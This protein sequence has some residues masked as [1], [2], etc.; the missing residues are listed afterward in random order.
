MSDNSFLPQNPIKGETLK[1]LV[2]TELSSVMQASRGF[3]SWCSVRE[4]TLS[5]QHTA[6]PLGNPPGVSKFWSAISEIKTTSLQ[7]KGF[8]KQY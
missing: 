6:D 4:H 2:I 8:N 7:Y 3:W 1:P 5:E